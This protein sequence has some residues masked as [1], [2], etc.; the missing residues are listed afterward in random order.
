MEKRI[1]QEKK[2]G[3]IL[4]KIKAYRDESKQK[5]LLVWLVA[6]SFCGLAIGSQMFL[7]EKGD[8]L[9]MIL[10]FMAFWA[11]FEYKVIKAFRWRKSGEEQFWITPDNL[12]Y[13]RTYANR[14]ILKPYRRDLVNQIR[15]LEEESNSFINAF[16]SSYWVVG[17][18]RLTFTVNGKVIAFGLRLS[19]KETKQLMK[20]INQQLD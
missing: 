16:S 5:N 10:I 20:T 2:D 3:G 13:G 12:S 11:Y 14:G 9:N 4:I 8:L 1:S 6:W 15:P 18:E 17:G 19:D 7:K